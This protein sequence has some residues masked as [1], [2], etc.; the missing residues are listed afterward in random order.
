MPR[1]SGS[2]DRGR[3]TSARSKAR[4]AALDLLFEAEQ[5]GVNAAQLLAERQRTPVGDHPL[6]PYTVEIVSGVVGHWTDITELMSQYSQGWSVERMPA[7]DRALLRVGTWEIA[8]NPD[9]PAGVAISEAVELASTLSTDESPGFVNGLLSRIAEVT[10]A[11]RATSG[12]AETPESN[13]DM[14]PDQTALTGSET[15]SNPH[16]TIP[17][18]GETDTD[19]DGADG[20]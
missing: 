17:G 3:L 4:R 6:R 14:A 12:Q 18:P 19:A 2:G 11:G 13:G 8:H 20:F 16:E 10:A 5:R 1:P 15:E 7:V 9:V